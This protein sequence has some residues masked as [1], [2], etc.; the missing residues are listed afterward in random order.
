MD[1]GAWWAIY[2]PWGHKRSDMTY[3]LST[4]QQQQKIKHTNIFDA[5]NDRNQLLKYLSE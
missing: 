4:A 1:R 5:K 2:S 3:R